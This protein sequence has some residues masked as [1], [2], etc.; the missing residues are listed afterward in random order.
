MDVSRTGER[1]RL[2]LKRD[3][4]MDPRSMWPPE[5]CRDAR[6]LENHG[7]PVLV[8]RTPGEAHRRPVPG[9][10]LAEVRPVQ[11]DLVQLAQ[12]LG[13]VA[14]DHG[15]MLVRDETLVE[16]AQLRGDRVSEVTDDGRATVPGTLRRAV[17]VDA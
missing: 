12:A 10:G 8:T 2:F 13:G 7:E 1:E 17:V 9:D 16:Q 6:V 4:R 5:P 11:C 15:P 3:R 14:G